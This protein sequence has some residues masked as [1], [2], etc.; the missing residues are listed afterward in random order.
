MIPAAEAKLKLARSRYARLYV[1]N[2][3]GMNVDVSL[4][5]LGA[6]PPRAVPDAP[7]MVGDPSLLHSVTGWKCAH[8]LQEGLQESVRGGADD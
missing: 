7:F 5:K 3:M 1:M 4:L 8:T 6:L 2:T